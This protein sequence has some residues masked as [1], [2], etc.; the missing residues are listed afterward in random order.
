MGAS[1]NNF[2]SANLIRAVVEG[3][4]FGVLNGL[5]LMMDGCRPDTIVAIGGGARSAEW[6]RLLADATGATIQVPAEEE[7]GCLGAAIQAMYAHGHASGN[8]EAFAEI[9]G[10]CVRMLES[11][12][13]A[14]RSGIRDAYEQA[15]DSY[16]N[17]LAEQYLQK[18]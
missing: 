3:V 11:G 14:P 16:R 15:R 2:T 18:N 5:D 13:E 4:S 1:A 10:R 8:A 12:G 17:L 9:T 6:R 7:A